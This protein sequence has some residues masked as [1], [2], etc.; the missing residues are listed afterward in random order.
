[1][2]NVINHC[3]DEHFPASSGVQIIAE[4]GRYFACSPFTLITNVFAVKEVDKKLLID[5]VD[6]SVALTD[7]GPDKVQYDHGIAKR[8]RVSYNL[9]HLPSSS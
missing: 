4:P 8:W 5:D 9:F 1:M 3:L 6:C 7:T 2:S